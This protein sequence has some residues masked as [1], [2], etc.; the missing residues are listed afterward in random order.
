M[1]RAG[2]GLIAIMTT[3]GQGGYPHQSSIMRVSR[4]QIAKSLLTRR[5]VCLM[6]TDH[7]GQTL[8]EKATCVMMSLRRV[9][10][11]KKHDGSCITSGQD[12]YVCPLTG[13][14]SAI[15]VVLLLP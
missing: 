7:N 5:D 8:G 1:N 12:K 11:G 13:G 9:G 6:I 2:D 15:V 3:F 14:L 10:E 4:T